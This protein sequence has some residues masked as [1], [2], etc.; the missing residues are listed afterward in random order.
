MIIK[1]NKSFFM[2]VLVYSTHCGALLLSMY[3]PILLSLKIGLAA[4]ICANF[5]WQG[6][7]VLR[8]TECEIR[9]EDD[10]S[11]IWTKN[12][13]QRRYRIARATAHTGF[14]RLMLQRT[15]ERKCAL[16]V[17]RDAIEPEIFH[18]LCARIVQRR[19]PVPD[20]TAV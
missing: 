8:A 16:L 20:K 17:P 10:G 14:V 7:R 3:L 11:C 5:W 4:L 6:R 2:T 12:G 13:E 18:D 15:G 19:L 9:L 1:I